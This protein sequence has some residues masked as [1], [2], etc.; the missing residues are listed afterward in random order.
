M[1]VCAKCICSAQ[2]NECFGQFPSR[3]PLIE[4]HCLLR[5]G[6]TVKVLC[7]AK[8]VQLLCL[9]V[10]ITAYSLKDTYTILCH[11]CEYMQLGIVPRTIWPLRYTNFAADI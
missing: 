11:R 7:N 3:W 6:I 8:E 2:A 4:S 5:E 10:L 9:F 1:H